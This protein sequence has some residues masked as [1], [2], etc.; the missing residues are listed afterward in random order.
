MPPERSGLQ[1]HCRLFV[2]SHLND[3]LD[4]ALV[5]NPVGKQFSHGGGKAFSPPVPNGDALRP[6]LI[7]TGGTPRGRLRDSSS[8]AGPRPTRPSDST[9]VC[10]CP[11]PFSRRKRMCAIDSSSPG[12][13]RPRST[14]CPL[15]RM[16]FVLPKVAHRHFAFFLA[17]AAMLPRHPQR[18]ETCV[19]RRMPAHDHHGAVQQDIR[20]F[21]KGHKSDGHRVSSSDQNPWRRYHPLSSAKS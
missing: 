19:A 9:I 20:T 5:S 3:D 1:L 15:I 4:P 21:I 16:P 8:A 10:S 18:I 17:H 13:N 12:R 11:W 7:S 14:L 6:G 2:A